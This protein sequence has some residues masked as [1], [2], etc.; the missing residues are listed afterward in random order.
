[1]ADV[2]PAN[3]EPEDDMGWGPRKLGLAGAA[4]LLV[5]GCAGSVTPDIGQPE[6]AAMDSYGCGYGFW[7]GSP[8]GQVAVRF[9]AA[10]E[11][12]AGGSL[13]Q[14]ATLPDAA[15]DA[16]VIIGDDLYA[17]W[18]DDVLEPGEPQPAVEE[19][20]PITA[21]TITLHDP[22][23]TAFCPDEARATVTG[24]EATRGDGTTLQL[25]DR[26]LSNDTWGCFAG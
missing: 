4:A 20:W 22:A 5:S 1:V 7:L 2:E 24:L 25:G 19:Q 17:N 13:P 14:E 15:W 6:L 16:T 9:A 12:A 11:L 26:E 18:C 3:D 21:G 10:N 23:P 8:D